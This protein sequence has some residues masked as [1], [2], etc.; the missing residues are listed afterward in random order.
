MGDGVS[1]KNLKQLVTL[2]AIGNQ[3]TEVPEGVG[4]CADSLQFLELADNKIV[5]LPKKISD[6]KK[7]KVISI[8]GNPIKDSKVVNNAEKGV[9]DLKTHLAKNASKGKKK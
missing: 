3:I 7:L 6:L 8:A 1:W 9:K 5:S 2:T 4:E